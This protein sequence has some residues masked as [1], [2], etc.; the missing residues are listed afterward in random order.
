MRP[1]RQVRHSP[2]TAP[3]WPKLACGQPG[4]IASDREHEV[5]D[6]RRRRRGPL[7]DRQRSAA[8]GDRGEVGAAVDAAQLAGRLLAVGE[9]QRDAR[10]A[11]QRRR[12][13]DRDAGTPHDAGCAMAAGR[14]ADHRGGEAF[15]VVRQ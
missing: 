11:P 6:A 4:R 15:D 1:P 12:A 2:A 5:A 8:E 3:M 14:E 7:D 9:D 13:A 10:M